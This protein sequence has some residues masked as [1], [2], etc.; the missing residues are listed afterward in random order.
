METIEAVDRSCGNA[1]L[2]ELE[3]LEAFMHLLEEDVDGTAIPRPWVW[4]S[5]P[6]PSTRR[7]G[8]PGARG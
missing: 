6:P 2:G 7:P 3:K 4:L 5:A 8:R 1:R